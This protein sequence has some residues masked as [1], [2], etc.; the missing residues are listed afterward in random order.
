MR[1]EQEITKAINLY[2]DTVR[3]ICFV[4]VKNEADTQDVFQNVFLKYATYKGTFASPEHEK[5]WIIRV[6]VNECND[7]LKS[8]FHARVVLMDV[9]PESVTPL[10][11]RNEEV[12]HAVCSLDKKNK[13]CVYLYYYEGYSA[14][15]IAEVL[16]QNVNTVYTNLSRAKQKLHLLLGD[17]EDEERD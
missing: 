2:A 8:F 4:H 9:L 13:D 5:A 17:D 6:T 1:S 14:K 3:R 10:T 7:F 15:E 11:P 12:F 16:K